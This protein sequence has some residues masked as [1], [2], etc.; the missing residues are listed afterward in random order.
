M[1]VELSW[2]TLASV[3]MGLLKKGVMQIDIIV[4]ETS[5]SLMK[6]KDPS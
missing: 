2:R 5:D 4:L 1:T 3:F 6:P